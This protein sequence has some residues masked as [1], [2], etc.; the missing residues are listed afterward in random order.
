MD[1]CQILMR[2][3]FAANARVVMELLLLLESLSGVLS[4]LRA[5]LRAICEYMITVPASYCTLF[6]P[7]VEIQDW[8]ETMMAYN[9]QQEENSLESNIL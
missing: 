6:W 3:P 4:M 8:V 5:T 9:S 1:T 7:A 2:C